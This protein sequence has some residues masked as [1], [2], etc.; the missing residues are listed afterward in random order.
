MTSKKFDREA[1]LA[2]VREAFDPLLADVQA[3]PGDGVLEH[4][5]VAIRS[6]LES[7]EKLARDEA[8]RRN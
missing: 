8:K 5:L 4:H 1:G 2:A 6:N 3:D 7:L